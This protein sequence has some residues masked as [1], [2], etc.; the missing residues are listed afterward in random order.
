MQKAVQRFSVIEPMLMP[1]DAHAFDDACSHFCMAKPTK[2]DVIWKEKKIAGAAQRK[3]KQGFLHQGTISLIP[4]N[5]DMLQQMLKPGTEVLRAMQTYTH[6][7]LEKG[8]SLK[9]IKGAKNFL[10]KELVAHLSRR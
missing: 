5:I 4:P 2:Y 1:R 3:T 9:E 7:L 6:A 8:A 10:A